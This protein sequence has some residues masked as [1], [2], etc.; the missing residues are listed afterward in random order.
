MVSFVST[1][2]VT[3]VETNALLLTANDPPKTVALAN[4]DP[5]SKKQKPLTIA[6]LY[7]DFC[8]YRLNSLLNTSAFSIERRGT[9]FGTFTVPWADFGGCFDAVWYVLGAFLGFFE[10]DEEVFFVGCFL[11]ALVTELFFSGFFFA[12]VFGS[13]L[14]GF[15]FTATDLLE[16]ILRGRGF[17]MEDFLV[18]GIPNYISLAESQPLVSTVI[19]PKIRSSLRVRRGLSSL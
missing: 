13:D 10:A 7:I 18:T 17:F 16:T 9:L 6:T 5:I 1:G 11:G 4:V 14:S 3:A 19:Q 15:D 8:Q 2:Y 12:T